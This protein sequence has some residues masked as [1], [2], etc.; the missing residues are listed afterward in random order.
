MWVFDGEEWE[1]EGRSSD[2]K[3]ATPEVPVN[4]GEFVPE[5][6]IAEVLPVKPRVQIEIP[7]PVVSH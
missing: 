1:E 5:L 4:R 6:Q 7:F 2:A 3:P